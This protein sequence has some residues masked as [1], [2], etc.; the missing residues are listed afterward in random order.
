MALILKLSLPRA[1]TLALGRQP[2]LSPSKPLP[3][4]TPVTSQ[5]AH[6]TPQPGLGECF[7][8][9]KNDAK[10]NILVITNGAKQT[11]EG[12]IDQAGLSEFVDGVRSCDEVGLAKPFSQVYQGALDLCVQ[13]ETKDGNKDGEVEKGARWFVA[14]HLWDLAAARKAG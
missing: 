6:L 7:K 8:T 13:V 4:L 14:A 1:I 11:T 9:L 5:L 12:Y 2:S 10:A 3:D